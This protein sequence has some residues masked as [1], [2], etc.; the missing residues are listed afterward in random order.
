MGGK[1][2]IKNISKYSVLSRSPSILNLCGCDPQF[3]PMAV[4]HLILL[5]L[6]QGIIITIGI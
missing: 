5:S 6:P 2:Y 3:N 1:K 4:L